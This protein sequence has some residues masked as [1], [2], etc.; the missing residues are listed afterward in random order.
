M[1]SFNNLSMMAS[2]ASR[3]WRDNGRGFAAG[4]RLTPSS[5]LNLTGSTFACCFGKEVGKRCLY[6]STNLLIS[7]LGSCPIRGGH[8]SF[9]SPSV[10]R[11]VS[12]ISNGASTVGNFIAKGS[13]TIHAAPTSI[14]LV[15]FAFSTNQGTRSA[16]TIS[17]HPKNDRSPGE[18]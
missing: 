15:A 2:T 11:D 9:L 17:G 8:Q 12:L 5:T 7:P 1:P 13:S 10:W 18:R 14:L 3:L 4:G 6:S 16:C